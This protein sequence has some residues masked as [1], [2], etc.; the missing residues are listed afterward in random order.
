[1]FT[2]FLVA[3][4][5]RLEVKHA[6]YTLRILDDRLWQTDISDF[7]FTVIPSHN[8]CKDYILPLKIESSHIHMVVTAFLV[9]MEAL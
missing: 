6:C 1:M 4:I 3:C 2:S 7:I 5:C 8:K 9:K